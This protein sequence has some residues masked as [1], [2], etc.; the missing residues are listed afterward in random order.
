MILVGIGL[1]GDT[2]LVQYRLGVGFLDGALLIAHGLAFQAGR[3]GS[4]ACTFLEH[5]RGG[6]GEQLVGEVDDFFASRGHGH[7]GDNAVEF[8]CLE[9]GDHAVEVAFDPFA[10]DFQL[11]ADCVAQIDIEAD[12]AAVG[13]FGFER[14]IRWIDAEAQFLVF[15]GHGVTGGDAQS[16]CRKSQPCF[17][18]CSVLKT[19]NG[20]LGIREACYRQV[21]DRHWL[22]I[23]EPEERTCV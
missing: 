20:A 11:F 5:Q 8:A 7:R 17:F 9:A 16:Q 10:F 15:L 3:V 19:L 13:C 6:A 12:Q 21:P 1:G 14:C 22:A 4:K 2:G 18:H 23:S